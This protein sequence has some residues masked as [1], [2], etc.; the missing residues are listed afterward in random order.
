VDVEDEQEFRF[1]L[2]AKGAYFF[3]GSLQGFG[4][5][6]GGVVGFGDGALSGI[7]IS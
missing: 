5:G 2:N 4:V 7:G 3:L 1:V 6:G